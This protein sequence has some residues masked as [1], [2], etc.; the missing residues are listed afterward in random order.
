MVGDRWDIKVEETGVEY[1][2]NA[3]KGTR[4]DLTNGLRNFLVF[5]SP[6]IERADVVLVETQRFS[7]ERGWMARMSLNLQLVELA[8]RLAVPPSKLRMIAPSAV[9][10]KYGLCSPDYLAKKKMT[11]EVVKGWNVGDLAWT[12]LP[13][14][15]R[16][17]VADTLLQLRYFLEVQFSK[18]NPQTKKRKFTVAFPWGTNSDTKA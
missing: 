15:K 5:I 12:N 4:D 13:E 17:H 6:L 14:E 18:S 8:I 2:C 1:I 10:K 9:K 7:R 11:Y 16:H 3:S